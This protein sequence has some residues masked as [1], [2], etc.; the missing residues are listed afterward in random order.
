M[1]N[2]MYADD[3]N[4][5]WPYHAWPQ[6]W[7]PHATG[8]TAIAGMLMYLGGAAPLSEIRAGTLGSGIGLN[9]FC[10]SNKADEPGIIGQFTNFQ[11]APRSAYPANHMG[12]VLGQ[13]ISSHYYYLGYHFYAGRHNADSWWNM[14]PNYPAPLRVKDSEAPGFPH[15]VVTDLGVSWSLGYDYRYTSHVSGTGAPSGLNHLYSDGRVEWVTA[16]QLIPY[17]FSKDPFW[18]GY[19]LMKAVGP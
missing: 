10:P 8:D 5:Y 18:G 12:P 6:T 3:N 19:Q 16:G 17:R 13:V 9:L 4:D 14:T 15:A 7:Y 1:A 2:L 11:N